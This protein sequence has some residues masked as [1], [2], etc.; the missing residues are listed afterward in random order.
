ME[1][2]KFWKG[3]PVKHLPK[4]R[5][6]AA[7]HPP[8]NTCRC[9]TVGL[10]VGFARDQAGFLPTGSKKARIDKGAEETTTTPGAWNEDSNKVVS[11]LPGK[12][13]SYYRVRSF[14]GHSNYIKLSRL[15]MAYCWAARTTGVGHLTSIL[16]MSW[17]LSVWNC[18]APCTKPARNGP[19]LVLTAELHLGMV[20]EGVS[21]PRSE[22]GQEPL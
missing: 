16:L 6:T 12:Q 4:A 9:W 20:W 13:R 8:C 18:L 11:H 10:N 3:E 21:C 5:W 2:I 17:S 15:I 19:W 7:Q 14:P 22:S 1:Y